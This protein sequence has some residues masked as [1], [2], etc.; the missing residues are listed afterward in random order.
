MLLNAGFEWI[1]FR[2]DADSRRCA[3]SSQ[4]AADK[5]TPYEKV[6]IVGPQRRFQKGAVWPADYEDEDY[7][8][9]TVAAQTVQFYFLCV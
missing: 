9:T 8:R 5:Y 6:L 7:Y 1:E 4:L 2:R 3:L